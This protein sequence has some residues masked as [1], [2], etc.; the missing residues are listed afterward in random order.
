MFTNLAIEQGP[1]IV[2]LFPLQEFQPGIWD[3][4]ELGIAQSLRVVSYLSSRGAVLF[5]IFR[6]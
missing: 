1:H 6:N 2:W 3:E 5:S 4:G